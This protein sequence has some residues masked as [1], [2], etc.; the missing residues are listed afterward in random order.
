MS[1]TSNILELDHLRRVREALHAMSRSI[2]REARPLQAVDWSLAGIVGKARISTSFGDLPI[3]ALRPRGN[4]RTYSGAAV[5]VQAVDKIHLD[6][7]F[8][9]SFPGALPIR[10]PANSLALRW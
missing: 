10:I 1:V 3:E 2:R 9:R 5:H 7:D 4:V 6:Q 8:M